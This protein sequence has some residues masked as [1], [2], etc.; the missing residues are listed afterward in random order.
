MEKVFEQ[1]CEECRR[2]MANTGDPNENDIGT[3]LQLCKKCKG[4]NTGDANE[5]KGAMLHFAVTSEHDKCMEVLIEA[6]A[7]VNWPD[8]SD[9]TPLM[10][11]AE[12]GYAK[13]VKRL[14][15]RS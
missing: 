7:D 15:S 3:M 14:T 10:K 4:E 12:C 6:G 5:I 2:Y 11:A 1:L 13:G 9:I 8:D